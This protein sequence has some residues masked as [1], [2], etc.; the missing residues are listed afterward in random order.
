ML[1]GTLTGGKGEKPPVIFKPGAFT[2]IRLAWDNTRDNPAIG[3]TRQGTAHFR[4][5]FHVPG[6]KG[7]TVEDLVVGATL[8]DPQG[9]PDAVDKPLPSGCDYIA[10]ERLDD[11]TRPVG[12]CVY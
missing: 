6:R 4:L 3:L 5:A 8:T 9:R 10:I 12:F 2:H 1:S 11:G 7:T